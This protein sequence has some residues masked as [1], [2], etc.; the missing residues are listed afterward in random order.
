M[1]CSARLTGWLATLPSGRMLVAVPGDQVYPFYVPLEAGTLGGRWFALFGASPIRRCL[2]GMRRRCSKSNIWRPFGHLW[3]PSEFSPVRDLQTAKLR[4]KFHARGRDRMWAFC[5]ENCAATLP[6]SVGSVI[7]K[8]VCLCS[9]R[10]AR[11]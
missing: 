11:Q 2:F 8:G 5:T 4:V 7:A 6:G 9:T 3:T 10:I 1:T